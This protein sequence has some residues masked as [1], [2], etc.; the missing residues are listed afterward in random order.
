MIKSEFKSLMFA[1]VALGTIGSPA[2]AQESVDGANEA[3]GN[4]IVVTARRKNESLQEVPQTVNVLQSD[5]IQKLRINNASDIAQVV[6]GLSIEGSS[7]GSGGFGAST[8]LRGVPTFGVS[9]ASPV[10]QFYLNDAPTGRGPEVS[11]ALFDIGQ[12]EVLKGPQGTLRG[13]AAPTGS[14]TITS[15]RPDLAEIGG[16]INLSGTD[17]G[18]MNFQGA[19]GLPLIK[20]ILALR[21]AGSIDQNEFGGVTSANYRIKPFRKQELL[22]ATLLFE[23]SANFNATVMYQ[24]LTSRTLSFSQVFGPGNGINGP[25]IGADDLLGISDGANQSRQVTDFIVGN[26][27]LKFAGQKLSYVGSYRRGRRTGTAPIDNANALP[28]IEYFQF[29][30]VPGSETSHELRLSSDDRIAGIFEYVVGAFY[31]KELSHPRVDRVASFLTGAFG[32]P[33]A[34]VVQNPLDRYTLRSVISIDPEAVEKSFFGNVTA[35]LGEKTELS[36]GG[37]FINFK[38]HDKFSI[39]LLG[40]FNAINNPT[41][42]FLACTAIPGLPA[43]TVASPV[44]ANACDIPIAGRN[45]QSVD[46]RDT[47]K[48]FTY[49]ISLSHKFTPDFMVFANVGSAFRSA[50]PAIGFTSPI[51]CCSTSGGPALNGIS[52]LIFHGQEKSKTYE[53]GFKSSLFDRRVRLNATIF[54]QDFDNFFYLTQSVRY[55]SITNPANPLQTN[56]QGVVTG[57]S[58]SASEF[59]ADADAKVDGIDVEASFQIT[60]RWSA[61]LGFTWSK[62]RLANAKVPCNDGN[63]DGI[64]DAIVPTQQAFV[65]AGTIVARCAS[66]ESISRT[67]RWNLTLQSEYSAP[68]SGATDGFVRGNFV[69]YPRNPDGTV[70]PDPAI[71]AYSLLNVFLGVRDPKNAWEVSL[72]ANNLLNTKQVLSINPVAPTSGGGVEAIFGRAPS[73]YRSISYTPRR[74]FG[75]QVRYAFGAR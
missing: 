73:G 46:R 34:P 49:N 37:R 19:L 33:G 43:G 2:Y 17:R 4:A 36:A 63:F 11:S 57:S 15:K 30:D 27:E 67:P 45:I 14:I 12:I 51:T 68:I 18:S 28:G 75:L 56:A 72:F 42:G 23:P 70:R 21:V 58:V 61:N 10:V 20:D 54:H 6:P 39:D 35:H 24:R 26:A 66:S 55:L 32:R 74:E 44:Y 64:P 29:T 65:N 47:F 71:N 41:G 31:D 22:R 1:G 5:V 9:N 62:A 25:N 60:P 16:F 53:L 7:S 59:T 69:Y 13:R 38:R 48:P 40:G 8:G 3:D 52:D 50:G